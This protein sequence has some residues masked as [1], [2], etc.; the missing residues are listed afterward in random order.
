[1]SHIFDY[2]MNFST[3]VSVYLRLHHLEMVASLVGVRI[4]GKYCVGSNVQKF[5]DNKAVVTVNSTKTRDELLATC[6]C[7]L[8]LEVSQNGF[9]LCEGP[10]VIKGLKILL[11]DIVAC[12]SI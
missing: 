4:C 8:G 1:M 3:R 5:C 9:H 6:K 2:L 12:Q 7:E 10:F 11:Q